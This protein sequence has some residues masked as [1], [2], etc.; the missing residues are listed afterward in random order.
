MFGDIGVFKLRKKSKEIS[1]E[2]RYKKSKCGIRARGEMRYLNV[3]SIAF[4]SIVACYPRTYGCTGVLYR[5]IGCEMTITEA[6]T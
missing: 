4:L 3:E 1:C 5:F 6:K 2:R